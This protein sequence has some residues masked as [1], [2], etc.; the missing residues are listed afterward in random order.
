MKKLIGFISAA[1]M[2][3]SCAD[4]GEQENAVNIP[5]QDTQKVA[6]VRYTDV[7]AGSFSGVVPCSD[8][9]G[10]DVSVTLFADSSFQLVKKYLGKNP[11]DTAGL[12][13]NKTGKF[14]MHNDT[15]HLAGTD[16]KFIK[17]DTALIQLDKE[18]KVFTGKT[19]QKYVLR[20]L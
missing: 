10:I 16:S 3:V 11:K 5:A 1:V 19:A 2:I 17:T 6:A 7:I 18:G 8:C 4:S 20:K 12:N 13:E 9:E 14:M 15:L